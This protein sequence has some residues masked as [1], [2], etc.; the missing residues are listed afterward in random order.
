LDSFACAAGNGSLL[1]D[2]GRGGGWSCALL[3]EAAVVSGADSTVFPSSLC[4]L[5]PFMA[6]RASSAGSVGFFVSGASMET[7][8]RGEESKLVLKVTVPDPETMQQRTRVHPFSIQ[9]LYKELGVQNKR[10]DQELKRSTV[11]AMGSLRRRM[12]GSA[13]PST[14]QL[15]H[16]VYVK[17]LPHLRKS[18]PPPSK[19][20]R[21]SFLL[22]R[23][24]LVF[25]SSLHF[26]DSTT[27]YLAVLLQGS[28]LDHSAAGWLVGSRGATDDQST[29]TRSL[30]AP[31]F[32][33]V[34][35]SP[36][37]R[38]G[39]GLTATRDSF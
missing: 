28:P 12:H 24:T 30:A 17:I 13:R 7:I 31:R 22:C 10:L 16:H 1:G 18:S 21:G 2:S 34:S 36:Q 35:R 39:Y 8:L 37:D 27:I 25:L 9:Q 3:S 23:A 38:N 33:S 6:T 32:W 29:M 20:T 26:T 14:E 4:A 5:L 19:I 15:S 11:A